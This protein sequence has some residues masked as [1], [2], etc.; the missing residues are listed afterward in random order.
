MTYIVADKYKSYEQVGTPYDYN[1]KPYI[2]LRRKCQKCGGSGY[3]ANFGVCFKCN[4]SGYEYSDARVYTPE[5]YEK[6]QLSLE[7]RREKREEEKKNKEF[8]LLSN[9][10]INKKETAEKLGFNPETLLTYIPVG[11]TYA[12]KDTL[13]SS[14]YKYHPVLGWHGPTPSV[15]VNHISISFDKLY[16]WYPLTKYAELRPEAESLVQTTVQET[17]PPLGEYVGEI[18]KRFYNYNV[19]FVEARSVC[20]DTC[21]LYKFITANDK[22]ILLWITSSIP[23]VKPEPGNMYH[24]TATVKTHEISNGEKITKINR[25]IIKE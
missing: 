7:R 9:S 19:R 6:Y 20:E 13:K 5:E 25:A 15:N 24:L 2:H 10:E 21:T 12:I 4:G 1:G 14:G 23:K 18:G 17:F 22:S 3:Y 11:N 8:E 16:E